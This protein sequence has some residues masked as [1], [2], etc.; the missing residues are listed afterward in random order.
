M[1]R[2][3]DPGNKRLLS[4]RIYIKK[5]DIEFTDTIIPFSSETFVGSYHT[6]EN[7]I[8]YYPLKTTER[9]FEVEIQQSAKRFVHKRSYYN[10]LDLLGDI[11]GV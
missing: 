6:V 11:G 7:N 2:N 5:N 4:S 9:L 10:L 1:S 3:L 8:D